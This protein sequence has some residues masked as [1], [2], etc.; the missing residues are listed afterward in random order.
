MEAFTGEELPEG[1][2]LGAQ[3]NVTVTVMV[4]GG[5]IRCSLLDCCFLCWILS[6]TND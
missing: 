2:L 1:A 3:V 6:E 5:C 4:P